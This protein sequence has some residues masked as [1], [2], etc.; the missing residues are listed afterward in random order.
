MQA[1]DFGPVVFLMVLVWVLSAIF[2]KK[3][4]PD[5]EDA[6]Q[7]TPG[8][9]SAPKGL[10]D[11]LRQIESELRKQAGGPAEPAKAPKGGAPPPRAAGAAARAATGRARKAA[12]GEARSIAF[13]SPTAT[14]H[15]RSKKFE[16]ATAS[17][18]ER[19][20]GRGRRLPAVERGSLARQRKERSAKKA[21]TRRSAA[22][23]ASPNAQATPAPPS[24]GGHVQTGIFSQIGAYMP[25][26]ARAIL[27]SEILREPFALRP[28]EA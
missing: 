15:Q 28:E 16:E 24:A 3:K 20:E 17:E 27:W 23:Q 11:V 18:H 19:G 8:G 13:A 5:S 7:D 25:D 6:A 2:G 4:P 22:P 12:Q 10:A 9:K 21:G 1:A 14:E 26:A